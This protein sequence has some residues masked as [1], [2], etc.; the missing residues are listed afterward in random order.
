M[1]VHERDELMRMLRSLVQVRL[2]EKDFVAESLILEASARQPDALYL[3]AQRVMAL[4]SALGAAHARIA[5]LGA[6][7]AAGG[8][9]PAAVPAVPAPEGAW[10]RG[11]LAQ[12][13][14]V[15]LGAAVGVVAGAAGAAALGDAVADGASSLLDGLDP[16]DWV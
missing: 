3:L 15:A 5:E 8:A 10:Q 14:A 1:D 13:A 6:A 11:L 2:T 9:R 16:S 12:G 4:Q 7:Q